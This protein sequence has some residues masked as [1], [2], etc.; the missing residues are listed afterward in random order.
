MQV[1]SKYLFLLLLPFLALIGCDVKNNKVHPAMGF[2]KIYD[3]DSAEANHVP[4]DISQLA[5]EGFLFLGY[6]LQGDAA[7]TMVVRTNKDGK[8]LWSKTFS[9]YLSPVSDLM[10]IGNDYYFVSSRALTFEILLLKINDATQTVDEVKALNESKRP[11]AACSTPDGG[12]LIQ[13]YDYPNAQTV[14]LKLNSSFSLDNS[15]SLDGR[16]EFEISQLDLMDDRIN[17]HITFQGNRLPFFVS[18]MGESSVSNY[19]FNG[20]NEY[21]IALV[22]VN[23]T[24]GDPVGTIDGN[25]YKK[26][27]SSFT[28]LGNGKASL[29]KFEDVNN[30]LIPNFS[31]NDFSGGG[32]INISDLPSLPK[33]EIVAN[34]QIKSHLATLKGRKLVVYVTEL[35]NNTVGFFAYDAAT[36]GFAGARY[37]GSTYPY[38]NGSFVNTTDGGL[39]VLCQT[40]VAGRFGRMCLFKLSKEQAEGFVN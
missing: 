2:T 5:D 14:L 25:R 36:G 1:L 29:S 6:N 31:T 35:K 38:K 11:L 18:Y 22:A 24:T 27:I 28:F 23:P 34:S 10:K 17:N 33:P 12:V 21:D 19:V 13:A 26:C 20:V 40:F 15:F 3:I 37:F 8:L 4:V 16:A 9:Q 30:F 7:N 39:A 32:T